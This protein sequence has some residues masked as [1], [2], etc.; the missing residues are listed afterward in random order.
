MPRP[1][2]LTLRDIDVILFVY[3]FE[4]AC[5]DHLRLRFWPNT[6]RTTIHARLSRLIQAGYLQA[7]P[8]PARAARGG[9]QFWLTLGPAARPVLEH[10]LKLTTAEL[11]QLRAAP[12]I[13]N[14]KHDLECRYVRLCLEMATERSGL[15]HLEDWWTE[16][17]L[18]RQAMAVFDTASRE[19]IE[20][21]PDGSFVLLMEGHRAHRFHLELDRATES[22]QRVQPRLRGYLQSSDVTTLF[23]V[24]H[25][26]RA[27]QL[28]RWIVQAARQIDAAPGTIWIAISGTVTPRSIIAEAIW[29]TVDG[30]RHAFVDRLVG[31]QADRPPLLRPPEGRDDLGLQ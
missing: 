16:R 18:R 24:P 23:V 31:S 2:S 13:A 19:T 7:A 6:A 29:E 30:A 8:L 5:T 28:G 4:G 12:I 9:G 15:V 26:A 25:A 17:A 27:R 1:F 10:H 14:W 3:R 22:A 21:L 20:L 11:R